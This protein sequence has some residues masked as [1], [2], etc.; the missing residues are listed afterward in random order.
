VS[1]RLT[2]FNHEKHEMEDGMSKRLKELERDLARA[3]MAL[4][5]AHSRVSDCESA[6]VEIEQALEVERK[7]LSQGFMFGA[8]VKFDGNDA[9]VIGF[10]RAYSACGDLDLVVDDPAGMIEVR[11]RFNE[12]VWGRVKPLPFDRSV[13]LYDRF[14]AKGW[15]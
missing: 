1:V 11:I 15:L 9:V 3:E 12:S 6:V 13:E 7:I 4:D 2:F 8:G 14:K 5:D 10:S